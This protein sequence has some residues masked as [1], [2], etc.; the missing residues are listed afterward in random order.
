MKIVNGLAKVKVT[1]SPASLGRGEC[2]HSP[3]FVSF[4][5]YRRRWRAEGTT[6]ESLDDGV[7]MSRAAG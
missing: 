7:S 5:V 2:S 1:A 3:A 4:D 6:H